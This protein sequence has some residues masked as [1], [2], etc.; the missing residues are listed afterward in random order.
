MLSATTTA[1]AAS[2]T[3]SPFVKANYNQPARMTSY[4]VEHGLD[5]SVHNGTIDFKKVKSAGV[6]FVILRAGYRGYGKSGS[7]SPDSRFTT[8][9]ADAKA[10]G[11]KIGVYFYSQAISEAEAIAEANYTANLIGSRELDLPVYFDYEFAGVSD[12]RL[13]SAYYAGKLPKAKM[14]AIVQA[15]CNAIAAKGYAAGVYS[16][17]D[18]LNN[19]YNYK[20][21]DNKYSVWNAH[22]TSYNSS[23]KRY[24]CTSYA[25]NMQ[26]WQYSASGKVNGI[27]TYVDSNFLYV[28]PMN[29]IMSA[30]AISNI[31][32]QPYTGK[33]I[34]PNPTV[35]FD[36]KKLVK[37]ED[38][39]VTYENNKN[40]GTAAITIVGVNEYEYCPA[41]RKTFNIVPSK[42]AGVAQTD[43]T[44]STVTFK[45][46]K[47]KDAAKYRVMSYENGKNTTI[48]TVKDTSYTL[49]SVS[50]SESIKIRISAIKTVSGKDY[51]GQYSDPVEMTASP[52]KVEGLK[53]TSTA[54]DSIRLQWNKQEYASYFEVYR[55]DDAQGKYVVIKNAS[56]NH[57]NVKDLKMN[58]KYTFKVRAVKVMENGTKLTSDI[59]AP[60]AAYTSPATPTISTAKSNAAKR[61]AVTWK[62][63]AGAS[64]YQ[65]MWSTSSTFKSNYLSVNVDSASKLSTVLTTSQSGKKYYV[66]VRSYKKYGSGKIYSGWSDTLNVKT[67]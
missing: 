4:S 17:T 8:Y 51:V 46:N 40:I 10:A 57:F 56:K 11:L 1:F 28:E 59:S 9:Y 2:Y 34:K 44:V 27:S 42:V 38:Y 6:D 14:T 7:L 19:K 16:N 31:A 12:G 13:D 62:K 39:Y 18:F 35:T 5:L 61:I 30:I 63:A 47:H 52:K 21:I 36:G 41:V 15:Y 20:E 29:R 67:K 25:G 65:V 26:M 32:S 23:T 60:L 24:G 58:K 45:W 22:Y 64:G 54:T 43:R 53:K 48:D 66:R 37:G 33:E 3:Y 50:P 49:K 55:Y